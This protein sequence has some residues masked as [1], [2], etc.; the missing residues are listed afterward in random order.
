MR[1]NR[2]RL[3]VVWLVA[4]LLITTAVN[5]AL[6]VEASRMEAGQIYDLKGHFLPASSRFTLAYPP[7]GSE[8]VFILAL[9][10][11][12]LALVSLHCLLA[13][14]GRPRTTTGRVVFVLST[15]LIGWMGLEIPEEIFI[16]S[17][18]SL[19]VPDALVFWRLT[20]NLTNFVAGEQVV[21][22]N[23][24][25]IRGAEI[26]QEK[27]P[28]AFRVL[29][30]G[31]SAFFGYGVSATQMLSTR[32]QIRLQAAYPGRTIEVLNCA[33]PGYTTY[34]G[35]EYLE[36]QG[37]SFAPDWIVV[38]FNDDPEA[39]LLSDRERGPS[40]PTARLVMRMLY[41]SNVYMLLRKW[42]VNRGLA[43]D[44]DRMRQAESAGVQVSRVSPEDFRSNLNHICS[45]ARDR[46]T[47]VTLVV[48]PRNLAILPSGPEAYHEVILDVARQ[49][50]VSVV[51]LYTDWNDA[52]IDQY[53]LK[54]DAMHPN[55]AGHDRM[56]AAIA[57]T[58]HLNP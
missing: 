49:F 57:R 35:L 23:A 10:G 20:P 48:M 52:S 17:H 54:D 43:G 38:G 44:F 13:S 27:P 11:V 31:D 22:T 40:T 8:Q 21:T 45:L 9:G 3:L 32:L 18:P 37:L 34:Q 7:R 47:R 41:R 28:G 51:N 26:S 5:V 1:P 14:L 24:F 12:L 16:K 55:A 46:G 2:W 56:A 53:F 42:L 39:D 6:H 19:C 15:L 36:S 33:V 25:G 29:V 30:L 4:G 50:D 58:I